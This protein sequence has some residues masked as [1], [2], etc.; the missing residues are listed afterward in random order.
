[1]INIREKCEIWASKTYR[2]E[3]QQ[4]SFSNKKTKDTTYKVFEKLQILDI[5]MDG[6]SCEKLPKT[7]ENRTGIKRTY[8]EVFHEEIGKEYF[9]PA[10]YLT[11]L[12]EECLLTTN[13]INKNV[14]AVARGLRTLTSLLREPDFAN[15]IQLVL[16]VNDN[17]V[18]TVLNS[19]LDS[20]DHTDV[21]LT[22][23]ENKR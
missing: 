16:K 4:I 5:P 3:L 13:D 9:S 2:E 22:Y 11:R 15:Q 1:M 8:S 19:K 20:S 12:V 6:Y 23:K 14:G 7:E 21:L 10:T 18:S 17:N